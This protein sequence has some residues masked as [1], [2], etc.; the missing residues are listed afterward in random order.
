MPITESDHPAIPPQIQER[1]DAADDLAA[2]ARSVIDRW[3][4]GD[5]AA[6]VRALEQALDRHDRIAGP[7]GSAG[8]EE[9]RGRAGATDPGRFERKDQPDAPPDPHRIPRGETPPRP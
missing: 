2:A 7:G 5:L 6:A 3:A 8:G 9:R 1:L 4:S